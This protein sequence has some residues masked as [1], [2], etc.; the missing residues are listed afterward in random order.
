MES[1]QEGAWKKI[2]SEFSR[3]PWDITNSEFVMIPIGPGQKLAL[4]SFCL[5]RQFCFNTGS[6]HLLKR[7]TIF[8]GLPRTAEAFIKLQ[9]LIVAILN[10]ILKVF[11][12]RLL[13]AKVNLLSSH[14]VRFH[15]Q[16]HSALQIFYILNLLLI[17]AGFPCLGECERGAHITGQVDRL[18]WASSEEPILRSELWTRF[19][20]LFG[21]RLERRREWGEWRDGTNRGSKALNQTSERTS[22]P[23]GFQE[24]REIPSGKRWSFFL[25]VGNQVPCGPGER[26]LGKRGVQGENFPEGCTPLSRST[27][28]VRRG[29]GASSSLMRPWSSPDKSHPGLSPL[30]CTSGRGRGGAPPRRPQECQ[31]GERRP[32]PRA[33]ATRIQYRRVTPAPVTGETVKYVLCFPTSKHSK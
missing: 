22:C 26:P 20:A 1:I 18:H 15:T 19:Q 8:E 30:H 21:P 24:S 17:R 14:Y 3:K 33:P 32:E 4:P 12:G 13:Y 5:C 29:A 9:T 23:R 2:P 16:D 10:S 31:A 25:W 7:K 27:G 6:N 11:G 28:L